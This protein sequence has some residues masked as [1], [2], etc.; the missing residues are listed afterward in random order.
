VHIKIIK[1]EIR[2]ATLKKLASILTLVLMPLAANAMPSITNGSFETGDLTGWSGTATSDGDGLNPFGTTYGSGMDG[3]HW[4]WLAGYETGRTLEQTVSGLSAGTTY[5]IRFIMAS[6]YVNNDQLNLSVDGG[7][8][9]LFTAPPISAT[10][11]D[12]WVEKTLDFT[13]SGASA[14]I[15]F[16]SFGLNAAGYDV[17]LDNVRIEAVTTSV[18][19]PASLGLLGLGLTGMLFGK[20]KKS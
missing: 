14:L 1:R 19:E 6:E 5:R 17:G 12:N 9:T 13:A 15:Q 11:W 2:M 3:A 16:S 10:F 4:M 8:A 18:P 20:R 7:P